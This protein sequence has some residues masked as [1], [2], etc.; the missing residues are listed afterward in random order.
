VRNNYIKIVP[1]KGTPYSPADGG[2]F[3]V[4]AGDFAP[5]NISGTQFQRGNSTVSGKDGTHSGTNAW[6]TGLTEAQYQNGTNTMLYSP[7]YNFTAAGTY[8][9]KFWA[10]FSFECAW[11]GFRIEV[12]TN[13][14]DSWNYAGTLGANWYN[15]PNSVQ[16]TVFPVNEPYFSCLQPNYTQYF[17]D[18]PLAGQPNVAFRIVAKTDANTQDIGLAMDDFEIAGPPNIITGTENTNNDIPETYRLSQNYPNPFNPV[19]LIKYQ[20]P[21]NGFV[22]ITLFD[23]LGRVVNVPVKEFKNAGYY[24]LKLDASNYASGVYFYKLEAGENFTDTKKMILIK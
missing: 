24:E 17:T 8:T 3:E 10:K 18:I 15:F 22:K 21:H 6:V 11:D 4:N 20:I 2:N 1:N 12:T 5:E 7:N 23:I 13:K 19:T 16:N 14:G 9:I